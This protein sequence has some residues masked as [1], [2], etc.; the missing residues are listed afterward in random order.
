M[1]LA[2][3][4]PNRVKP[5]LNKNLVEA[6]RK[7]QIDKTGGNQLEKIDSCSKNTI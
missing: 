6:R 1:V 7:N 4:P 3:N 5:K 2:R